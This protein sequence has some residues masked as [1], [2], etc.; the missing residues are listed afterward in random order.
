MPIYRVRGVTRAGEPFK[1]RFEAPAESNVQGWLASEEARAESVRRLPLTAWP[2]SRLP[3]MI[4]VFPVLCYGLYLCAA[5]A[6]FSG[7]DLLREPATRAVYERLARDGVTVPGVVSAERVVSMRGARRRTLE[8]TFQD[9][10]GSSRRGTLAPIPGDLAELRHD[11]RLLMGEPAVPGAELTVTVVPDEP[12]THAPFVVDTGLLERFD[13]LSHE[14]R[15]GLGMLA[16]LA[17][18]LAW[19]V[20]NVLVRTGSHFVLSPEAPRLVLITRG[21]NPFVEDDDDEEEEEGEG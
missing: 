2:F 5:Q 20:W 9:P 8:Y 1:V 17:P 11:L 15:R 13:A 3:W 4:L 14:L 21:D 19:M 7:F 18:L 6:V 16:A 10:A 12:S